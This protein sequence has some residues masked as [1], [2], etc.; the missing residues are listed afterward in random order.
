MVLPRFGG[1][2]AVW[3]VAIIFFQSAL[4]AGYGYAHL[5]TR[6]APLRIGVSAHLAVMALALLTLP[7]SIASGWGRPPP[8][9]EAPWL[10]GLFTASI[11]LPFFALAGHN[12]FLPASLSPPR[13]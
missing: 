10:L 3:S 12:P 4:L 11:G 5:L 13:Q 7:I 8:G 1:A 2:P 6:Y 9:G